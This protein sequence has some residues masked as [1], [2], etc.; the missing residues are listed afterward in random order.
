MLDTG[1]SSSLIKLS[2]IPPCIGINTHEI[3]IIL[4]GITTHSISTLGRITLTFEPYALEFHVVDDNFP[5]K[6]AGILGS[7]I[8]RQAGA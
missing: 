4:Q 5:R 3:I 7:D 2:K 6:E 1:S 8:F